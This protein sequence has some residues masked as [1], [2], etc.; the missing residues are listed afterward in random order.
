MQGDSALDPGGLA[1]SASC[2]L[3]GSDGVS[4]QLVDGDAGC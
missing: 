1:L 4:G 3:A 2:H